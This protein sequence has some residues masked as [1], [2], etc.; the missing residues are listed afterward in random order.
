[1]TNSGT[2]APLAFTLLA[3]TMWLA[4]LA[5]A[6]L[7]PASA[8]PAFAPGEICR[9]AIASVADRDPKS[10]QITRTAG[11][12]L[13]LT[14]VRP[15]DNFIWTYRCRIEGQRVVWASEPGRWR[16]NPKDDKIFFEIIGA[17]AQLRIIENHANG[18]STKVLFD[19]DKI[20]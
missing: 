17:G 18:S 9:T 11:G 6:S 3:V 13:F 8:E 4:S 1:M 16:E 12:V 10:L 15:V 19:R 2:K 7:A 20:Q 14:Y 5:L